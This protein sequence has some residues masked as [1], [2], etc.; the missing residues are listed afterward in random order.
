MGPLQ[1]NLETRQVSVNGAVIALTAKEYAVLELL[2]IRRGGVLPKQ[3][4]LVHLYG[5][6]GNSKSKMVD[7]F[8]C[9]IRKKLTQAGLPNVIG[10]AWGQGYVLCDP[11]QRGFD[12]QFSTDERQR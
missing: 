9:K 4:L 10:T 2:M 3:S 5:K 6:A 1:L 7:I 8:I 12:T 11:T